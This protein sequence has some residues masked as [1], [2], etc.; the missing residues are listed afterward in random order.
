V[1]ASTWLTT[2]VLLLFAAL[3]T[4]CARRQ[5]KSKPH[6]LPRLRERAS[7]WGCWGEAGTNG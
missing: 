3:A 5:E 7:S 2:A 6:E 4:V 1:A